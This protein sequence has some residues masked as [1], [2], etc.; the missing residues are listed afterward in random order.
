MKRRTKAEREAMVAAYE[1]SG[2]TQAAFARKHRVK[3]GTLQGWVYRARHA[4]KMTEQPAPTFVEV[5]RP[6]AAATQT[7]GH[8]VVHVSE[9]LVMELD[10]VPAASWVAE[11]ARALSC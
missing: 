3:L 5:Q 2:L 4:P 9:H 8:V 6:A 7:A 10:E 1:A 11:L